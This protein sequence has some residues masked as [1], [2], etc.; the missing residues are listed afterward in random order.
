MRA[1]VSAGI[2][3][4]RLDSPAAGSLSLSTRL[5]QQCGFRCTEGRAVL[6]P[7]REKRKAADSDDPHDPVGRDAVAASSGHPAASGL[8]QAMGLLPPVPLGFILP[9]SQG[10]LERSRLRPCR[11]APLALRR[12]L[13]G[14]PL[15]SSISPRTRGPIPRTARAQQDDRSDTCVRADVD[16]YLSRHGIREQRLLPSRGAALPSGDHL[17]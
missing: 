15:T 8:P 1:V 5:G 9:A 3:V 14:P 11:G 16:L 17:M 6:R 7:R 13:A 2:S 4:D 10:G 12:H